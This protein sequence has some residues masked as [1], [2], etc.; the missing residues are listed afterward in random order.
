M[1]RDDG[2]LEGQPSNDD[3]HDD[4]VELTDSDGTIIRDELVEVIAHGRSAVWVVG[5]DGRPR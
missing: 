2:D 4:V 3:D 1:P 5:E